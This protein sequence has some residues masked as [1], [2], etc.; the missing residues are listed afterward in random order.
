M[1][2]YWMES[3]HIKNENTKL[4]KD[5]EVDVCII[6][7][8]IFG[9][10]TA[11]YLSKRGM[12]VVV[13]EKDGIAEK[14]TGHTTAKITSQHGLIYHYLIDTF[15]LDFAKAYLEANQQAI[16]NIETIIK[17]ENI[18]CDFERQDNYVYTTEASE[19]EKIKQEKEAMERIGYP[20][21]YVTESKLPFSILAGLKFPNQAQFHPR[22]YLLGLYQSIL[23]N[24]GQIYTNTECY[25]VKR[26]KDVYRIDTKENHVIAKKV[27]IASHYPFINIP[28][29]YFAKMYQASSYVL[30]IDTKTDSLEGMYI[31]TETPTYSFRSVKDGDKHILLLGGAGHKTGEVISEENSYGLLETKAKQLYPKC[32]ILY[33]WSTRDCITL[34]KIP[35]IGKFS[36]MLPEV[37]IGTGFNKW[38]MTSSNVAA[39]IIADQISHKENPFCKIFFARRMDPIVNKDEVK[40]MVSQTAKSLVGER[41]KKEELTIEDIANDSGGIIEKAG[42]K[43]G[44]YKDS[45][46]KVFAVKPVCTHLGC[47]LTWNDADKT[48]DCPCHGSRFNYTGKNLYDPAIKD[49]EIIPMD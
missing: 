30:G 35:Y 20:A 15:G 37:Y 14:T 34:D 16:E 9:L 28:G 33:R 31:N 4:E 8:G 17:E 22:K 18:S 29:F 49:L 41:I 25:D 2:S 48:W 36:N 1:N 24:G 13:L 3:C 7:A 19:I 46:G 32:E 39:N 21:E 44:I 45:N 40:N 47:I 11:Y 23:K 38:G 5:I 10:T 42:E 26:E 27:V 43:I 6:G 12:K